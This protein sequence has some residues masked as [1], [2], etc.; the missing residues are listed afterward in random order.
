MIEILK[1]RPKRFV[2]SRKDVLDYF[3]KYDK[4]ELNRISKLIYGKKF[5]EKIPSK[6]KLSIIYSVYGKWFVKMIEKS[7]ESLKKQSFKDIE[8]IISEQYTKKR[9][10]EKIAK[11]FKIKYISEKVPKV[12]KRYLY[13]PGRVRN[14][15]RFVASNHLLYF[16]DADILFEDKDFIKKIMNFYYKYSPFCRVRKD[17]QIYPEYLK[18]SFETLEKNQYYFNYR[19]PGEAHGGSI[20][21]TKKVFDFVGGYSEQFFVWGAEDSD[22]RWKL[23]KLF[24]LTDL[25][26]NED[27]KIKHI[28]HNR[29]YLEEAAWERNIFLEMLRRRVPI[30]N[31]IIDDLT[32]GDSPYIKMLRRNI[33]NIQ[34]IK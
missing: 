11:K 28:D 17:V 14:M 33:K 7:I 25:S 9:L 27:I 10:Y 15:G 19:P 2:K 16:T 34:A 21:I 31:L 13:N 26:K 23:N 32:F 22:L 24:N 18:Y 5:E 4:T 3:E 6:K 29:S 20:F 1:I 8:I 12:N 30:E